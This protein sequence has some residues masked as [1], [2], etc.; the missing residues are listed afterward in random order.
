[1]D[2][3]EHMPKKAIKEVA[4]DVKEPEKKQ[5]TQQELHV[6]NSVTSLRNAVN[7]LTVAVISMQNGGLSPTAKVIKEIIGDLTVTSTLIELRK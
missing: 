5:P 3:G 4:Q 7:H 2:K 6:Q 1:M